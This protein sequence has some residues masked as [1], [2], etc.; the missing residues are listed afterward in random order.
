MRSAVKFGNLVMTG[1]DICSESG[2]DESGLEEA[3]R[4][5]AVTMAVF[6]SRVELHASLVTRGEPSYGESRAD[7]VLGAELVEMEVGSAQS[8]HPLVGS[9]FSILLSSD[10]N[11]STGDQESTDGHRSATELSPL[12][13]IICNHQGASLTVT[14][15]TFRVRP[16]NTLHVDCPAISFRRSNERRTLPI[17]YLGIKR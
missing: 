16:R 10:G 17:I 1:G 3:C 6:S 2:G 9:L 12:N 7:E 8:W 11:K 15:P 5:S 13:A 14:L 4:K